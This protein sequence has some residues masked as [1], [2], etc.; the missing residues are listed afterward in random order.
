MADKPGGKPAFCRPEAYRHF[1]AQ[2]PRLETTQGLLH[3][4]IG[5]SMHALDDVEPDKVE[6]RLQEL[7][8]RVRTRAPSGSAD[9][10][11][12]HLH[13]VLFAEEGFAGDVERYYV[14][15]NSYLPVVLDTKR[16]LPISLALVYKVVGELAGL[17]VEGINAPG[18]FL[19]RVRCQKDWMMVDP[20][21][22]GEPLTREEAHQRMEK[23]SQRVLP[24]DES[25]FAAATHSQ[26][27][28]RM[29]ANL[30]TLFTSEGRLHDRAAMKELRKALRGAPPPH[31]PNS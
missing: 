7:A 20:F 30:Q 23:A 3:A 14:A 28:A 15:V 12:A 17:S 5:L 1:I 9:A 18:H 26:W 2:L 10:L 24:F 19:A 6:R 27:I 29:L 25:Y 8:E 11:V 16:G 21:F 31:Q 13:E 22:C 4:A